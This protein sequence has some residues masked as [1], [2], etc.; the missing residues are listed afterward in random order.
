[1]IRADIFVAVDVEYGND[2]E[3][4]VVEPARHNVLLTVM[5]RTSIST[6]VLAFD[7]ARVNAA[8]DHDDGFV[9]SWRRLRE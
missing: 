7:F 4:R 1:M 8:L 6:G 9:R 3:D 5:S 2:D